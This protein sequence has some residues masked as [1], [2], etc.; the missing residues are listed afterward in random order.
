M[1]NR[2]QTL[3][4]PGE[5]FFIGFADDFAITIVASY[6]SDVEIYI[7]EVNWRINS[8][9]ENTIMSLTEHKTEFVMIN[10]CRK[11]MSI[12]IKIGDQIIHLKP[13]FPA[14]QYLGVIFDQNLNLKKH[15]QYASAP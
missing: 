8:W 3:R 14:C 15:L 13:A 6:V 11:N 9:L 10:K 5:V 2:V 1:Y 7:N 12:K 4:P